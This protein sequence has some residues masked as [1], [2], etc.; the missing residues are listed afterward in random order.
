[1]TA[2][3]GAKT[4][5]SLRICLELAPGSSKFIVCL[6]NLVIN[7]FIV[8]PRSPSKGHLWSDTMSNS[9]YLIYYN[10]SPTPKWGPAFGAVRKFDTQKSYDFPS[11]LLRRTG[12]SF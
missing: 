3:V 5:A 9:I 2:M 1:M 7:Y 6:C 12:G 10:T 8:S 4:K 11:Q